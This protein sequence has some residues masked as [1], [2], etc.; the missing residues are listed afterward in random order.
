MTKDQDR[1]YKESGIL[2]SLPKIL[3]SA[4]SHA[5]VPFRLCKAIIITKSSHQFKTLVFTLSRYTCTKC[6]KV[7]LAY[8]EQLKLWTA[9]SP[10]LYQLVQAGWTVLLVGDTPFQI[11][12]S[13]CRHPD[14]TYANTVA[15]V[16]CVSLHHRT[17][18]EGEDLTASSPAEPVGRR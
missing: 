17:H 6:R 1:V 4:S 9:F 15:N 11:L 10:C 14:R 12:S 13:K 18:G 8:S 7:I 16:V 3:G 5:G 2:L